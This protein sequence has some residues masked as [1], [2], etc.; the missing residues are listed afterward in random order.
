MGLL[1]CVDADRAACSRAGR[2]VNFKVRTLY[3][4]VGKPPRSYTN[5]HA[6]TLEEAEAQ[7]EAAWQQ[8]LE[9]AKLREDT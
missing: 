7:F 4:V 1:G 5:D 2:V 9:W 6:P 8:W 3:G